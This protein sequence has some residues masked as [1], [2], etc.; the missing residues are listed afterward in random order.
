MG[1]ERN[2]GITKKKKARASG[3]VHIGEIIPR[4]LRD[5]ESRI[6]ESDKD[7]KANL[8]TEAEEE[9]A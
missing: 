9:T 3:F 6:K 2:F 7:K 5:V 8:G 1:K 4:V